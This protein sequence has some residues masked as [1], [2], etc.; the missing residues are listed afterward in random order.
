MKTAH[1]LWIVTALSAALFAGTTTDLQSAGRP[2]ATLPKLGFT[3]LDTH[4]AGVF[5]KAGAEIVAHDPGTQRLFVVNANAASLDVLDMSDP[6]NLTYVGSINLTFYGGVANSVAARDGIIA[7]AVEALQRTQPGFVIFFDH[8][9]LTTPMGS[10][11]V[12]AVPDMLTFTPN[13]SFLLVANEGE[14]NAYPGNTNGIVSVD[15]EGS[16]SIIDM[17]VGAANLTQAN[18]RTADFHALI[19]REDELRAAGVRIYGPGANAA[20]DLEPEY[21]A[22]S[23]DSTTAWVTLQENNALAV[24]DIETAEVTEIVPLGYKDHLLAQNGFGSS[25][26]LDTSDRDGAGGTASILIR[27]MPVRGLYLPDAIASYEAGGQTFLVLANEGDARDYPG[28]LEEISVGST[29]FGLDAGAF[30]NATTLKANGNLGRMTVTAI[31]GVVGQFKL[32]ESNLYNA[33][34]SFGGR[35][36]SIR[37]PNGQ[38]VFDSGDQFERIT[39][40]AF[41]TNFNASHAANTMDARSRSKGPEPEGVVIGKAYGRTWA[42]VVLERIGGVMAYDITDP[43]AVRFSSYFNNRNFGVATSSGAAPN[44]VPNPAAGDLGPEGVIFIEEE[45]S[46]TGN[47]L[48]V[49]GNEISSTTTVI[50]ITKAK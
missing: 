20:Q 29:N 2:R 10:V 5:D 30:P 4:G 21:I 9:D 24:I 38:L 40:A 25:N 36:F 1:Q 50:E 19:G 41:P 11:N 45:N 16:V 15:P 14:P 17:S 23:P 22:L 42:F 6:R 12:G 28:F 33:I 26:E 35:S 47:P 44:V 7:V 37:K 13:G 8:N 48:L 46:P 39:A 3:V 18:V 43:H 49:I 31:D 34:Y 32:G 27:N